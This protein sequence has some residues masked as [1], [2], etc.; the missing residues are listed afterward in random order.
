M[1]LDAPFPLSVLI[2]VADEL[3]EDRLLPIAVPVETYAQLQQMIRHCHA[4]DHPLR[5][6]LLVDTDR[7]KLKAKAL[8]LVLPPAAKEALAAAD[9][10]REQQGAA[11]Q[12]QDFERAA[13]LRDEIADC[14]REARDACGG[15]LNLELAHITQALRALG[16]D[17][18][19]D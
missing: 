8:E 14:H 17:G 2:D 6:F 19:L 13:L 4:Q 3:R 18:P 1:P 9:E 15:E 5:H 7:R 16:Y 10:L 12:R 11:I